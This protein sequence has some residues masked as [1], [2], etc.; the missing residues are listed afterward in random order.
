M[1]QYSTETAVSSSSQAADAIARRAYEIWE[2]EGCPEGCDLKHWL[3]AEQELR[4]DPSREE[5]NPA[6]RSARNTGADTRPLQGTRAAQASSRE[7]KRNSGAPFAPGRTEGNSGNTH[8][9]G[10]S[11][12]GKRK[13]SSAPMM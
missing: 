7:V 1:S 9:A 3:Q 8:P 12:A 2:R 6:L 11:G 4:A 13:P 10:N 5:R